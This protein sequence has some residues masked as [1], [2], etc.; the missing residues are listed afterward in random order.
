MTA[1]HDEEGTGAA[2]LLQARH[3]A[4]FSACHEVAIPNG[5]SA[6]VAKLFDQIGATLDA[7]AAKVLRILQIK[8]KFAEL[9]VYFSHSDPAARDAVDRLVEVAVAASRR[10]CER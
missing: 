5:W 9:R 2:E 1:R 7:E 3:P 6:L 8:Q 10:T 4:W